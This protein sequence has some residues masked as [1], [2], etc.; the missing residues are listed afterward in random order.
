MKTAAAS[1][2]ACMVASYRVYSMGVSTTSRG[3]E[4]VA[5]GHPGNDHYAGLESFANPGVAEVELVSD[6]LAAVCPSPASRPTA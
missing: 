3:S 1:F 2:I 6:E 4:F 5:L